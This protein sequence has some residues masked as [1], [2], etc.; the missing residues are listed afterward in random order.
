MHEAAVNTMGASGEH[1]T[2]PTT[3]QPRAIPPRVTFA[4]VFEAHFA[5][6]YGYL[7]RRA[8]DGAED[9]AAETFSRALAAY[10]RFDPAHG[11]VRPWL[12]GIATNV[13]H[14]HRRAEARRLRA[15]AREAGRHPRS[16][17]AVGG[18][19]RGAR[20]AAAAIARL[21]L[22]DRD[23]LLL[24]A[25]GDLSSDEVAAAL[26][27]PAGTVRSRLNRAR[28]AIRAHLEEDR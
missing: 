17:E 28:A 23:V 26:G 9:M 15:Y 22:G 25:W 21:S 12:L 14:A 18:S 10:A 24:V 16:E 20:R 8:G 13:V 2:M 3:S 4:D 19:G 7:R 27:I 5:A 1:Q 11:D 6:V